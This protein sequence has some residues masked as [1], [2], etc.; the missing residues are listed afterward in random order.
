[1]TGQQAPP[2]WR[3]LERLDAA[4]DRTQGSAG[5]GPIPGKRASGP[6]GSS[7][8]WLAVSALAAAF[9]AAAA[10]A[11]AGGPEPA[12]RVVSGVQEPTGPTATAGATGSEIVVDVGGAVRR[13]GIVRLPVG[14]RVAD[15]IAAAGGFGPRVDGG[16]VEREL[17]LAAPLQDGDR[18]RVPSRDD[19]PDGAG[20]ASAGNGGPGTHP[21]STRLDLNSATAAELE[22]LPGIGPVTA[23]KIIAARE[24]ARFGSVEEL[25][26]RKLVGPATFEKIRD[27]VTVR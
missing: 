4:A 13:P 12:V 15:A 1:M 23:A 7:D 18:I 5:S 22:A 25:R 16:R 11:L 21:G 10:F 24:A 3:V 9:L 14:S 2:P 19:P 26:T 6:A 27:L 8:R 17:N 20:A